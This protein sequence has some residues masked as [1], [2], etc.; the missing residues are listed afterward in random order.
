[1]NYLLPVTLDE[2]IAEVQRELAVRKRVYPNFVSSKRLTQ[3]RADLQMERLQAALE[4]LQKCQGS[5]A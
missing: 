2:Q 3:D 5:D 1:M 4:T